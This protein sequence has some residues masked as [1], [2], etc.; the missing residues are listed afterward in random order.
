MP[1]RSRQRS[2]IALVIL[3]VV[4]ISVAGFALLR[5]GEPPLAPS[6]SREVRS[7][8]YAP[9]ERVSISVYGTSVSVGDSRSF[10]SLDTGDTSWVHYLDNTKVR[11]AGGF[12]RSGL[13]TGM[14]LKERVPGLSADVFVL[15]LG[16]NDARTV[17]LRSSDP[18]KAADRAVRNLKELIR[19]LQPSRPH[20]VIV[21]A[22]GPMNDRRSADLETFEANVRQGVKAEG[23]TYVDPRE[24]LHRPDAR[25]LWR[26]GFTD[27]NVHPNAKGAKL[28]GKALQQ[29]I[30]AASR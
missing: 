12:A 29:E 24:D 28:L 23:W 3:T 8:T 5:P 17:A 26:P 15:E 10:N 25:W 16:T 18:A 27:D 30:L 20:R 19:A 6:S 14:A 2:I 11:F 7:H 22:V 9:D 4:A 21:V 13:T 1:D